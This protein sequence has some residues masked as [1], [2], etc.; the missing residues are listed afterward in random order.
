LTRTRPGQE[1]S[2]DAAIRLRD[3]LTFTEAG[4]RRAE[5]A[6]VLRWTLFV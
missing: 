5:M 4:R 6:E 3:A 2:Q 1:R